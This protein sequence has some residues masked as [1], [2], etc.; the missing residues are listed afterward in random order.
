M[1]Q[2][3]HTSWGEKDGAPSSIE[4]IAQTT[5]G[6]LWL[7]CFDGLFRFDGI[8]FEKGR[9]QQSNF[10]DYRQIR[11]NEVP[12]FEV[13]VMPSEEKPGG[14]GE[15]G[16]VSAAPALANAIFAATGVRLRA[17]PIDRRALAAKSK[18]S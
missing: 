13:F 12:P 5:D 11:M 14:L 7:A 1:A 17:L 9:V 4:A 10:H 18:Q 16:T 8:T 15:V 2:Y 3:M 6:Y